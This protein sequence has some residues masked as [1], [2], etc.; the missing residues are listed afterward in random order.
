MSLLAKLKKNSKIKLS[1]SM[2]D[3]TIFN[4]REDVRISVPC[5]NIALSGELERGL[6]SGLTVIAGPSRHYKSNMGLVMLASYMNQYPESS[7]LFYDSEFGSPL[8]YWKSQGIDTDRVLHCP[9][10]D[11]EELKFDLMSQLTKM[12]KGD[13]VIIFIDSVGN[14]ASKKEVEDAISENSAADMTRAKAFKSLFRMVT[15]YLNLNDIPMICI[16]HTYKTMDRFPR[17]VLSGGTGIFLSADN[18]WIIGR[19]QDKDAEGLNGYNFII[20]VEKSRFVKEKSKIPLGVSF[21]RGIEKYSGL[22]D[23]ALE[24]GAVV[25]P[26]MGWY[27]L[28]NG[29]EKFR[30]SATYTGE[31]WK[32]ILASTEFRQ[33]VKNK[34]QLGAGV[35]PPSSKISIADDEE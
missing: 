3:S 11:I 35:N 28:K 34:Y 1:D 30:E 32:D 19:Q 25:K 13:K 12:E 27:Q 6:T 4:N 10:K 26:S 33:Y 29:T 9:I 2:T 23:I 20:N 18:I 24:S 5:M 21:D 15:P 22:L 7:V 16:G 31:F 8:Q 17:D 14:L